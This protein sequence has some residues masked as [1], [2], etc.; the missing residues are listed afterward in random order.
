L[1]ALGLGIHNL[2]VEDCIMR[3]KSF[4]RKGFEDRLLAKS[5]WF[6]WFVRLFVN[7]IYKTGP[8]EEAMK[9]ILR[10]KRLFGYHGNA[11]R[12]AVTTT[13]DSDCH[14]LASYNWGDGKRYLNSNIDTW[15]A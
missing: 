11:S 6:G 2:S 9:Q 13:V 7:S 15:H 3:F 1:I 5:Y 4:C 10:V 14:L 12:V 8:L